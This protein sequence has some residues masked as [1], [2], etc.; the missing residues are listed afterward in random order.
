MAYTHFI[1]HKLRVLIILQHSSHV[2]LQSTV[3]LSSQ[4]LGKKSS[5]PLLSQHNTS[6]HP[7]LANMSAHV[8]ASIL[9]V[10][11]YNFRYILLFPSLKLAAFLFSVLFSTILALLRSPELLLLILLGSHFHPAPLGTTWQNSSKISSQ[12]LS[13]NHHH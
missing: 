1:I 4:R 7:G 9:L 10:F 3:N 13:V 11:K 5:K 8:R 12:N 6:L 2:L